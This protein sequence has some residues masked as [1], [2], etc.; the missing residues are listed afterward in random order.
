MHQLPCL[1]KRYLGIECPGC[2]LQTAI[3]LLLKGEWKA[4][5]VTYPALFGLI[6]F[7]ILGGLRLCG[8]KKITSEYLKIIGFACLATILISYLLKLTNNII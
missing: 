8:V 1:I 5:F 3:L 4:A 2:G 6:L 7:F